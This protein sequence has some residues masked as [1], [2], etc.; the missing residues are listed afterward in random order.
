MRRTI[1]VM[2]TDVAGFT[3]FMEQNEK[4]AI[5]MLEEINRSITSLLDSHSGSLVKEMGD[6]TLSYFLKGRSAINCARNIQKS[7]SERNFQIRIGI[8]WGS[9]MLQENDILGDTVNVA[10]RL[11]KMAPPGGI[12]VSSELLQNLGAGRK[13]DTFPLGLQKLKG[14]GRL[15]N[16]FN[17][18]GSFREPLPISANTGGKPEYTVTLSKLEEVPSI[19]VMPLQNLGSSADDFYAFGITSDLVSTL[20]A[21]G[22]IAVTP[23]SDLMKLMKSHSSSREIADKLNVRF[24]LKGSLWKKDELFQLSIEL[25]D[26]KENELIWVDNWADNWLELSSIKAKLSD[27]LLKVLGANPISNTTRSNDSSTESRAYELYLQ[28]SDSFYNRKCLEDIEK[29]RNLL[30]QSL[31]L[32]PDLAI[33]ELLYGVICTY[34]G[35]LQKAMFKLTHAYEIALDNG[36]RAGCINALN[37]TGITQGRLSEFKKA[38]ASFLRAMMLSRTVGDLSSEAK[39]LSNI[40][41][42]ESNMGNYSSALEYMEKSLNIP[43]VVSMGFLKA[44]T[45][46]NIGL[47]H[48]FMGENSSALDFYKRSLSIYENLKD[49][50]GQANLNMN[51]GIVTRKLGFFQDSLAY[52]EKALELNLLVGDRMGQSRTLVGIG[53]IHK[54]TGFHEKSLACYAD[55]MEIAEDI[56]DRLNSSIIKTN[57][58]LI[59]ALNM[60]FNEALYYYNDALVISTEISDKEG[61]GEILALMGNTYRLKGELK[62]A[63]ELLRTSIKILNE[64]GAEARTVT[65]RCNLAT[66]LL[67][68]PAEDAEIE[69]FEQIKTI[70][71][72]ITPGMNDITETLFVLSNL[73]SEYSESHLKDEKTLAKSEIFLGEAFDSLMREV[74]NIHDLNLK[75]SFLSIE[76]NRQIAE[77]YNSAGLIS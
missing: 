18:K 8:H 62:K 15:I 67:N 27:G 28:A 66:I 41:L 68:S 2:F 58:G 55:A 63:D 19:A 3:S 69:F 7:L 17:V 35:E 44:N 77:S 30:N 29:A 57:I 11:E 46:C 48:W 12:C 26:L 61:E 75:E 14:L 32:Q 37:C 54:Y 56:G 10:S 51:I 76:I 59:H 64:I 13:P 1:A 24:I 4:D 25:H 6:G 50:H 40:G 73:Y 36:E 20:A 60:D 72:Y 47:T 70:E 5:A 21:S 39:A 71:Q 45:L 74:D 43:G 16:L 22:G 23:L 65:A 53:N 33:A 34:T 9:V 49:F 42:M 38:K 52:T 31:N